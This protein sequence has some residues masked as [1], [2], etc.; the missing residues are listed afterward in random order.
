MK[1]DFGRRN[2]DIATFSFRFMRILALAGTGGS[3][4]NECYLVLEKAKKNNDQS[5]IKEWA[6]M[7]GKLERASRTIYKSRAGIQCPSTIFASQLL[8]SSSDVLIIPC[9]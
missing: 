1:L 6:T 3:E 2:M 4:V 8:L 5:W 9:R 7:A